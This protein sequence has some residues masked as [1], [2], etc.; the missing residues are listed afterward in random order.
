MKLRLIVAL[1]ISTFYV[2][3]RYIKPPPLPNFATFLK[4]HRPAVGCREKIIGTKTSGKRGAL[5]QPDFR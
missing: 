4:R 1:L 5:V 3:D 2:Q